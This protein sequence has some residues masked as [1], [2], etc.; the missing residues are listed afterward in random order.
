MALWMS[1]PLTGCRPRFPSQVLL[2]RKVV[3][4]EG[5][6]YLDDRVKAKTN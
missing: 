2:V 5:P 6:P 3:A 4:F 1:W